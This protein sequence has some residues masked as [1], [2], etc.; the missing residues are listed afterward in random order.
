[1]LSVLHAPAWYPPYST[2][3]IESYV[4]GLVQ[5][6]ERINIHSTV[7]VPRPQ[8]APFRYQYKGTEVRTYSVNAAPSHAKLRGML[9]SPDRASF[10]K[11]LEGADVY[12]QHAWTRG[13]GLGHLK[14]ARQAGLPTMCPC[15]SVSRSSTPVWF[16]SRNLRYWAVSLTS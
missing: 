1:M 7:A 10:Q 3:G 16:R 4:A 8:S 14:I 15:P 12:H 11:A 5:A 9:S 2:G 13:C 6:L